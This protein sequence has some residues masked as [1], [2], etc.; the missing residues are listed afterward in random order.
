MGDEEPF[1]HPT[2]DVED[3]VVVGSRT[4]IWA[5]CHLRRGVRIGEDCV[6]GEGVL[7]DLRV[8]IGRRCKIQSNAL[9]YHGALVEDGVFIGPAACL[10]NDRYPRA[11]TSEGWL[12][13][14]ADWEVAGVTLRTGCSIGAHATLV[15][16]VVVGPWAVVGAGSV[17]TRDVPAHAVVAGNPARQRGWACTCGRPLR[18][19]DLACA[20]GLRFEQCPG[21]LCPALEAVR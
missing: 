2:A 18:V 5:R 4:K 15:A 20:C 9:V 12:K 17:V 19:D 16:G 7:V 10:T 3:D 14:D 13:S 11:V 6:L 1:I 21:G 8:P